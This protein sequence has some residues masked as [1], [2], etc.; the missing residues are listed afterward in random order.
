MEV[1]AVPDSYSIQ[2]IVLRGAACHVRLPPGFGGTEQLIP[3]TQSFHAPE[4]IVTV[5]L[6]SKNYA[7]ERNRLELQLRARDFLVTIVAGIKYWHNSYL[8]S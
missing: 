1:N 2:H 7:R 5:T 4:N 6:T 3:L 8:V